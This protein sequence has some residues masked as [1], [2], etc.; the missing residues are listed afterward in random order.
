MIYALGNKAPQLADSV[1]V[2]DNA[3]IVGDVRLAD[4]ASVW[5]NTVLRGDNDTI[6]IGTASN[7]QEGSTLHTDLGIPLVVG[8]RVTVGHMVMLHGCT[9]GDDSLIGI[10]AI[11]LNR[12]VIGRECLIGAG[13]LIP[14]GKSIPDRSVVM[15]S[16]GKIVRMVSDDDLAR[17]RLAATHYVAHAHDYRTGLRRLA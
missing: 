11:I 15:G 9:I 1:W 4:D 3:V 14:E 6:T 16:P 7:I 5:W 17:I 2:A 10:G 13:T 12:A 8:Q